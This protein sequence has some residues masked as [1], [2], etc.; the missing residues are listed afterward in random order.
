MQRKSVI[1]KCAICHTEGN[2]LIGCE[3]GFICGTCFDAG[4]TGRDETTKVSRAIRRSHFTNCKT[5]Y[6]SSEVKAK[7]SEHEVIT[8]QLAGTASADAD[9]HRLELLDK[10]G[11][12]CLALAIDSANSVRASNSHETMLCHQLAVAH[13]TALEVID[14][15]MLE[16]DPVER[17]RT[18]GVAARFMDTFQR[19]LLTL[20]RLRFGGEQRIT[21]HHVNVGEGGQAIVGGVQTGGDRK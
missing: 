8:E 19:G 11:T 2:P 10:V 7:S 5:E 1:K 4:R 3:G 18:L 9:A 6:T 17:V 16:A 20:Q 12:D 15:G 13:K 14:K 21:I